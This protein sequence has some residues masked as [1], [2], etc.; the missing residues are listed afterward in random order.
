[1]PTSRHLRA[2]SGRSRRALVVVVALASIGW[3]HGVA[4]AEDSPPSPAAPESTTGF[5]EALFDDALALM[6]KGNYAEAC[7]K[8]AESHRLD[9]ASGTVFNLAVCLDN[10]KKYASATIAF[11]ESLARSVRD[12]NK[13]REVFARQRLAALKGLVPHVVVKIGPALASVEGLEV[14]FDGASVRRQAWGLEVPMDPGVHVL[15]AQATGRRETR[16]EV[17]VTEPGKTYTIAIDSLEL[18]PVPKLTTATTP[19]TPTAPEKRTQKIVGIGLVGLGGALLVGGGLS[20]ALAIGQKSRADDVCGPTTCP[21]EGVDAESRARAY[22]WGA[23]IGIGLGVVAAG[24]GTY[25]WLTSGPTQ[26][27]A[28]TT[29]ALRF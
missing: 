5:A 13:E 6:Q 3:A 23:N 27:A 11:D 10:A 17:D 12:G 18:E 29:A 21:Q 19:T 26:A 28:P 14:R 7:P 22:A 4:R 9:P 25:L 16:R 24:I 2:S 15:T 8:L 20:G 1:M